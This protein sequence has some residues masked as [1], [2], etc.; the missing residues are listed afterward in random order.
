M[1]LA[2]Y[3][4]YKSIILV[5]VLSIKFTIINTGHDEQ[6]GKFGSISLT[7]TSNLINW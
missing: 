7:S 5:A 3:I 4:L 1:K 2:T 6:R